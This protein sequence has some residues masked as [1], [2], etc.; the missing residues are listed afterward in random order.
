MDELLDL[1]NEKDEVIGE[2]W[3]SEANTNP[4][5][6]HREIMVYL[7]DDQNRLLMQQRSFKKKVYP[8]VWADTAAGHVGKGEEPET[9]A[10]RELRE[11]LGFDTKLI[12]YKKKIFYY[13]METHISY[14][15]VG[16]YSGEK[17][18]FDKEE[19]GAVKLV[20]IEEID[21]L[22]KN[23]KDDP[24]LEGELNWIKEVWR[25]GQFSV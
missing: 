13:P 7:F 15:Y 14:C 24:A 4:K 21:E 25:N 12:L 19:I 9:A 6:I 17:I 20:K 23:F 16:K 2:V 10:H 22:Y 3:K 1:V 11:E 5:L 18:E 8:G